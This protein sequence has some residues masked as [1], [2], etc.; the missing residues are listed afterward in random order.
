MDYLNQTAAGAQ[1]PGDRNSFM[2]LAAQKR[3]AP[4]K[5]RRKPLEQVMYP[6]STQGGQ[7]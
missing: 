7:A 5:K 2:D 1:P 4:K 3:Q 6:E